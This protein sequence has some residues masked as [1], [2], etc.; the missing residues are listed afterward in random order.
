MR[1]GIKRLGNHV[2]SIL[3][4]RRV[5]ATSKHTIREVVGIFS[6]SEDLQAAIDDLLSS[7]F[8]RSQLSL[9]ASEHAVQEKLGHQYRKS[10]QRADHP[11]VPRAPYVSHEAIGD[12]RGG[13]IG[14][15]FYVGATATAG[16][17]LIS[18]GTLAVAIASAIVAGA[19]GGLAGGILGAW[20]GR[21][22][23]DYLQEQLERGGLLLWVRTWDAA[24]EMRA[25]RIL[26]RNSARD[27]HAHT[28][29]SEAY[30]AGLGSRKRSRKREP[31][32]AIGIN[33]RSSTPI[34]GGTI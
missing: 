32:P 22:H 29:P 24:D 26:N 8:H 25:L 16:A 9:L 20:I 13:L 27:A 23:A 12:A 30:G 19:A 4:E 6:N 11:T 21:H 15:L 31:V 10:Q 34:E 33:R 17:I 14:G 7:G 1:T 18:G 3:V 2:E 28:L 5:V